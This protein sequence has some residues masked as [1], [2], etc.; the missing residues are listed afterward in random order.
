VDIQQRLINWG[1]WCREGM[2]YG[3]CASIEHR[4]Q[5][6]QCWYPPE[7]KPPILDIHD[8]RK[9]ELAVRV[10]IVDQRELLRLHYA[11]RYNLQ[12]LRRRFKNGNVQEL[13]LFAQGS[14]K[15]VLEHQAQSDIVTRENS[16]TLPT[17]VL[18]AA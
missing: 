15:R 3:H 4:Y 2:S 13:L 9:V 1:R 10:L 8:G 14:L 17:R 16:N 18:L 11:K 12:A 5:S 7:A 6:P